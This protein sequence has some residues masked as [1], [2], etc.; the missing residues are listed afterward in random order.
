MGGGRELQPAGERGG[1]P[2]EEEHVRERVKGTTHDM[3]AERVVE[4]TWSARLEA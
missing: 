4:D 3:T 2:Q 1:A